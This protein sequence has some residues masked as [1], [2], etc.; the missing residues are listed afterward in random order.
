MNGGRGRVKQDKV[1]RRNKK[2][3]EGRND[4]KVG[5]GGAEERECVVISSDSILETHHFTSFCFATRVNVSPTSL[6]TPPSL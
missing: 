5:R 6:N 4:G 3:K 2:G 1:E